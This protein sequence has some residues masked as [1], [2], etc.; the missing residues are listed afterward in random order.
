M[1]WLD[2]YNANWDSLNALDQWVVN[3]AAPVAQ[4]VSDNAGV[5]GRTRPMCEYP[6]WPRYKGAGD[7]NK[8][9]S[10]D[11]VAE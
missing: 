3:G 4:Q 1:G 6:L 7:V 10:F 2:A 9:E 8:A 5:P 11:C